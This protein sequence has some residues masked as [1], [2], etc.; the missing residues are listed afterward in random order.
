[1]HLPAIHLPGSTSVV[2]SGA[3]GI[4][5]DLALPAEQTLLD[6]MLSYAGTGL[7]LVMAQP[8]SNK[9]FVD[10]PPKASIHFYEIYPGRRRTPVLQYVVPEFIFDPNQD[11]MIWSSGGGAFAVGHGTTINGSMPMSPSRIAA[12][13]Y[14]QIVLFSLTKM[15]RNGQARRM[16]RMHPHPFC[17]MKLST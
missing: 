4:E 12:F 2:H 5:F 14:H 6:V 7:S 1:M 15:A 9:D 10:R 11:T 13:S 16:P 3:G 8:P 17:N